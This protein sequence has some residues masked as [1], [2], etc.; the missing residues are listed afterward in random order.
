MQ[1]SIQHLKTASIILFSTALSAFVQLQSAKTAYAASCSFPSAQQPTL[2]LQ[3]LDGK[4]RYNNNR[5]QNSLKRMQQ[6]NGQS[7]AFG[8]A[9]VPVGLTVT[10]IKYEIDIKIE[11]YQLPN[12]K[13]CARLSSVDAKVGY[14]T[15]NV[16]IA[17]QFRPGTCPYQSII[18]HENFHV[19]VFQQALNNYY[20]RIQQ[21]LARATMTLQPAIYR[22]PSQAAEYLRKR[23]SAAIKPLYAEMGR[24]L[25]RNNA[26]LDTPER[27]RSEQARCSDW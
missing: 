24:T 17:R 18:D 16:F 11:A 8:S 3:R 14:D 13:V 12:N 20:P 4:V 23:L 19:A 15:I 2:N 22:T 6:K 7:T 26:R 5:T 10:G 9:W 1:T 21:R 27:Y 25:K